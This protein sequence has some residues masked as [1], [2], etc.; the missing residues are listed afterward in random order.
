[1]YLMHIS[2]VCVV[3]QVLEQLQVGMEA[4]AGRVAAASD[5]VNA[6]VDQQ[7]R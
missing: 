4:L 1:M 3:V 2:H 5:T 6:R 7:V